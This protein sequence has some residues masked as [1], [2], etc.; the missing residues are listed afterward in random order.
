MVIEL[1]VVMVPSSGLST[2]VFV[3]ISETTPLM[4][5]ATKPADVILDAVLSMSALARTVDETVLN[6]LTVESALT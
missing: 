4:M 2:N 5:G 1:V 3:G 6:E